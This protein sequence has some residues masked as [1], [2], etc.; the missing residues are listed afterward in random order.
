MQQAGSSVECFSPAYHG[1][2]RCL[3]E[4]AQQPCL[5]QPYQHSV[6]TQPEAQQHKPAAWHHPHL[7]DKALQRQ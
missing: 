3:L 1:L 7:H 2:L 5:I 6:Y 4:A